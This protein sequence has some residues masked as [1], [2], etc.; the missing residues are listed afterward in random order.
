MAGLLA[1]T[2]VGALLAIVT[3]VWS[4]RHGRKSP[5]VASL[6]LLYGG[7]IAT[8]LSTT[9]TSFTIAQIAAR[10][11]ATGAAILGVVLLIESVSPEIR[12]FAVSIYA[13][14]ASLGSGA[15]T[16][17]IAWADRSPDTW[18]L[19]FYSSGLA[20]A[21]VP[22]LV[23][24]LRPQ[25]R[26]SESTDRWWTEINRR[27]FLLLALSS[28]ALAAFTAV[29][30]SFTFERL[31]D[32]VGLSSAMAAALSLVAGTL[33]GVGFLVGGRLA[34]TWGRRPT[35]LVAGILA[36]A[37]GTGIFFASSLFGLGVA[38]FT[39]AF[40]SF[41]LAPSLGT[42][43]NESFPEGARSRAVT[44]VH[45]TALLG[46]AGGLFLAN[47]ILDRI[48]LPSVVALLGVGALMGIAVLSRV[49]ETAVLRKIH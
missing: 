30:V 36:I 29:S 39:G 6:V 47:R 25:S 21:I 2:R 17:A 34:D 9:A 40:G 46:S 24:H 13:A 35:A 42:L 7:S 41:M 1:I 27:V 49:P 32:D 12:G 20:L 43:R 19:I 16:V 28:L 14:A 3:S 23:R 48:G 11:G 5:Y 18:R 4:D 37:G 15:A 31:I 10:W 8:G 26:P 22:L 44:W 45:A 33:G 38:T